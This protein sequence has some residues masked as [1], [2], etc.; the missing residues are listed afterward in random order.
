MPSLSK[1][2]EVHSGDPEDKFVCDLIKSKAIELNGGK[3]RIQRPVAI[4]AV[5]EVLKAHVADRDSIHDQLTKLVAGPDWKDRP[6]SPP[7]RGGMDA[8]EVRVKLK[9]LIDHIKLGGRDLLLVNHPDDFRADHAAGIREHEQNSG[10]EVTAFHHGNT[11]GI[12]TGRMGSMAEVITA[13]AHEG[14]GHAGLY[15]FMGKHLPDFLNYITKHPGYGAEIMATA[16]ERGIDTSTIEGHHQ[17]AK[18]W[19]AKIAEEGKLQ[20][21]LL[22]KVTVT[23]KNVLRAAGVKAEWLVGFGDKD[24]AEILRGSRDA[25][26]GANDRRWGDKT[27]LGG[28]ALDFRDI[29]KYPKTWPAERVAKAE[30]VRKMLEKGDLI[31]GSNKYHK[32]MNKHEIP[33]S[34]VQPQNVKHP[35]GTRF[36]V[37]GTVL[38]GK[39]D[40][41]KG[42]TFRDIVKEGPD[43]KFTVREWYDNSREK[44]RTKKGEIKVS[45]TGRLIVDGPI[46]SA[47]KA[48]RMQQ[49]ADII[50]KNKDSVNWYQDW[51]DYLSKH[52]ELTPEEVRKYTMI[53]AILSAQSGPQG[54][55]KKFT[56]AVEKLIANGKL[57]AKVDSVSKDD[58]KKINAIWDGTAR[59]PET[60]QEFI[61]AYGPKVGPYMATGLMPDIDTV[62]VDRHMPRLWGYNVMYQP[63][64]WSDW[65]MGV[66]PQI[67]KQ[68]TSEIKEA[69]KKSGATPAG[70]Q[71]ALWYESRAPDVEA[72]SYREAA[73]MGKDFQPEHMYNATT[74]GAQNIIHFGGEVYSTLKG[75]A[76]E[77]DTQQYSA[78]IKNRIAK[79]TDADPYIP[80]TYFYAAG[81]NPEAVVKQRSSEPHLVSVKAGEIYD[82]S[83]D[84]L[85]F[86]KAVYAN[87]S[88]SMKEGRQQ[89]EFYN[90]LGAKLIQAGYKGFAEKQPSTG[91]TWIQMFGDVTPKQTSEVHNIN[92]SPVVESAQAVWQ[93]FP[94]LMAEAPQRAKEMTAHLEKNV[95]PHFPEVKI[96]DIYP[97]VANA[98]EATG[99]KLEYGMVV[100]AEGPADSLKA[101]AAMIGLTRGQ[102]LAFDGVVAPEG[103]KVEANGHEL[104][105]KLD[106]NSTHEDIE[107]ALDFHQIKTYNFEQRKDGTWLN[108]FVMEDEAKARAG[109]S[110]LWDD[111]G[112]DEKMTR[113]P[114]FSDPLGD[115]SEDPNVGADA[116][117]KNIVNHFG[118][119]KGG[120]LYDTARTEGDNWIRTGVW[121]Q[122]TFTSP[123]PAGGV[124][125]GLHNEGISGAGRFKSGAKDNALQAKSRP[126]K[127]GL[128]PELSQYQNTP[129]ATVEQWARQEA[130]SPEDLATI[131]AW[132]AAQDALP[133]AKPEADPSA[134][135]DFSD[136]VKAVS[137]A[138][139]KDDSEL[140]GVTRK[141]I[142]NTIK[143]AKDFSDGI[144]S[145]GMPS[146]KSPFHL[147]VADT[148]RGFFGEMKR[149]EFVT[150]EAIKP[151]WSQFTKDGVSDKKIPLEDNAGLKFMADFDAGRPVDPKYKE[152]AVQAQKELD[153]RKDQLIQIGAPI[154]SKL[155]KEEAKALTPDQ[156]AEYQANGERI[157]R[158][159]YFPR[160][161]TNDSVRAFHK[162]L[163]EFL[164]EKFGD[165]REAKDSFTYE[166]A[167]AE[168]MKTIRSRAEQ[169][170]AGGT[171]IREMLK[172]LKTPDQDRGFSFFSKRPLKGSESF[173]KART[174]DSIETA[175]QF[176]LKPLSTNPMDIL[177]LKLK[178]MDT[179][180]FGN[181]IIKRFEATGQSVF[182]HTGYSK[183]K[184]MEWVTDR[185]A[186]VSHYNSD[187]E[188]VQDG[189][190]A[191]TAEVNDILNNY[192]SKNLYNNK[193][194][195]AAFRPIMGLNNTMTQSQLGWG[196]MFHGGFM[197]MN[198]FI[199]SGANNIKDIYSLINGT[200]SMSQVMDGIYHSLSAP[201]SDFKVGANIIKA[202]LNP[203]ISDA[204]SQLIARC[205]ELAG[206]K[207]Y[208]DSDLRT[209]SL[210]KTISAW[211]SKDK[212]AMAKNSPAALTELLA[213]PIMNHITP[214]LKVGIFSEI[215]D[216]I[217]G[218]N[219]NMTLE[220]LQPQFSKAWSHIEGIGGQVG[221]DRLFING[222]AK[223][224]IQA[225]VRS[226]GWTGGTLA[227]IGGGA[228][229][230]GRFVSEWVKTGKL[231]K[232]M[233]DRV[234]Y[235][236]SMLVGV[237]VMNGILTAAFTGQMPQGQDFFAFRTGDKDEFGKDKRFVLPTYGKDFFAY[238]K[239]FWATLKAKTGPVVNVGASV[240]SNK[241]YYG[242]K[243]YNEDDSISDKVLDLGKYGIKQ[244]VPFFASGAKRNIEQ[245]SGMGGVVAPFFGVMPAP[246]HMTETDAEKLIDQH[247]AEQQR[248]SGR[249]KEQVEKRDAM[250]EVYTAYKSSAGEGGAALRQAIADGQLTE[251]DATYIR[252]NLGVDPLVRNFKSLSPEEAIRVWEAATDDEKDKLREE[253]KKKKDAIEKLPGARQSKLMEKYRDA[254]YK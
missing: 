212:I 166:D 91:D 194:L 170:M 76:T 185:F 171:S 108:L 8:N 98:G 72:S 62:V 147:V 187:G 67:R 199:A 113:T 57:L 69:A 100:K 111:I 240:I 112:T 47:D 133:E 234:A 150:G 168:D 117:R 191:A 193:Y 35:E 190:W 241:D 227:T 84:P 224:I 209:N 213:A 205:I 139:P 7:L 122:P 58:A 203:M 104:S 179:S 6:Q 59:T 154:G 242:N 33:N 225:V 18:E 29:G 164:T 106:P 10:R 214:N 53:Q 231:P 200:G 216:R 125:L 217:I 51:H 236:L 23:V 253:F 178:E 158:E 204:H 19:F 174:M 142:Y 90:V 130:I 235:T 26:F 250:K 161:W 11:I 102:R 141:I 223:N 134:K 163:N 165:D 15:E 221:Y 246:R 181:K 114:V 120:Q 89:G 151:F 167:T 70:V 105:F 44:Y 229:D 74:I 68:I 232:N 46:L 228:A 183:P 162:S 245:G 157:V 144:L 95:L 28:E 83:L 152:A 118:E 135:M 206:G 132:H 36:A 93:N 243:V 233:P 123:P 244:F 169:I 96:L 219:P 97:T 13:I 208:M 17:A 186:D 64:E 48:T 251:K 65:S 131:K 230:T 160:I 4:K 20:P 148:I 40:P 126:E 85:H 56:S 3:T 25:F 86:R 140:A 210:D 195:G 172:D 63:K 110:A 49:I 24:M 207:P 202:Y 121:S 103:G 222:V 237:G 247:I 220:E 196:S 27:P 21:S 12:V 188:L 252:K 42:D 176:G 173:R 127:V 88:L 75:P 101:M 155:S 115:F 175:I 249:T 77:A 138:D 137:A 124:G 145:L 218:K 43:G 226:A 254:L 80:T 211:Y 52:P 107:K 94:A 78:N 116:F 177:G 87:Q 34:D 128:P 92:V 41:A 66:H 146:A 153:Q 182:V 16:R 50:K 82:M 192:Q 32:Y 31:Q 38:Y 54:N 2:L 159:N 143:G 5:Q 201:V 79:G 71:A 60:V 81:D 99:S 215:C 248:V 180:I 189:K 30:K 45:K 198:S 136:R 239:A 184:G 129:L 9:G 39:P 55:Q 14:I 1:C 156:R 22:S 149:S 73:R 238:G 37:A 61:K 119:E 197:A 109:L